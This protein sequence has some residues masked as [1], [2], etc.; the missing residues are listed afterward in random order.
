M[1]LKIR[2]KIYKFFRL[3]SFVAW[4]C[5]RFHLQN[6]LVAI[7]KLQ[8]PPILLMDFLKALDQWQ[9]YGINFLEK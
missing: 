9:H 6:L 4:A 3:S 1:L 8:T 7:L 2:R 5:L